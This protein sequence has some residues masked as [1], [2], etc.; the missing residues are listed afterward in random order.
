[1]LAVFAPS[2]SSEQTLASVIAAGA[3]PVRPVASF[4]WV[5]QSNEAGL[6]GRLRN[7]GARGV[8]G[9]FTFGPQLDGCIAYVGTRSRPPENV[10]P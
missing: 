3:N 1:M 5:A 2:R 4:I 7:Q 9:A 10:L 6:A 8:F